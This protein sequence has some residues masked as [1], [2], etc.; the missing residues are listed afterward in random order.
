[1]A[2]YG[3]TTAEARET[4]ELPAGVVPGFGGLHLETASTALV[5]LGE[6]ARYLVEYPYGCAEQ[7]ASATLALALAADLGDAFAC[8]AST[9]AK[10]KQTA[11]ATFAELAAFQC[12][13]GGFAFWKGNCRCAS[14]YLT[15]YVLHVLQRGRG[16]GHPIDPAVRSRGLG[17]PGAGA[18][19]R[20]A[21]RRG[22][23]AGVH[24][25]AGL[26]GEGAGRGRAPAGQPRHPAVRRGWTA[27][28][29]SR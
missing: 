14:P 1:M 3:Q 2:A 13:D 12:A 15:S 5:G 11:S 24:G 28:P 6:G 9:P 21:G 29:S 22:L 16:L 19:R 7:R 4:L 17:L 25:V 27:C 18:R 10:L 20:R 8:P 23:V 26:C